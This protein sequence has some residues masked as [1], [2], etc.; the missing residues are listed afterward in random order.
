MKLFDTFSGSYALMAVAFFEVIGVVYVYG[1]RRYDPFYKATYNRASV[2]CF[3]RFSKD[4]QYM[5]G[6]APSMFWLI[7]WRFVSPVIMVALFVS[8]LISSLLDPPV[9]HA[10]NKEEVKNF[11]AVVYNALVLYII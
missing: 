5:T 1:W 10:Y 3:F 2:N 9:Y 8:S 6:E 4:L 7:L 11:H